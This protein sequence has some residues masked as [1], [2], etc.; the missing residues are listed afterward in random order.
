MEGSAD[1]DSALETSNYFPFLVCSQSSTQKSA[2][3]RLKP[4]LN[5]TDALFQ[6]AIVVRNDPMKTCYHV[7]M[8]YEDA[9][10]IRDEIAEQAN[11]SDEEDDHRLTLAPMTDLMKIQVDTMSM[12][13]EKSWVVPKVS[14]PDDWERVVRVG[15]SVGHRMHLSKE[16][17]ELIAQDIMG[18]IQDVAKKSSQASSRSTTRRHLRNK[19]DK[20][21]DA[22]SSTTSSSSNKFASI[23]NVLLPDI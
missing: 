13:Y 9:K 5:R 16:D 1:K 18:D 23:S 14:S 21:A 6:D 12:I 22:R 17:V 7:S 4:M 10:V 20:N 15:L 8:L 3:S 19:T 11:N 2:Y